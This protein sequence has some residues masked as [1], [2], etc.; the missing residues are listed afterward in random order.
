MKN[1][2]KQ[3]VNPL[4]GQGTSQSTK[5]DAT[6]LQR[7][8]QLDKWIDRIKTDGTPLGETPD[9]VEQIAM[10]LW[11]AVQSDSWALAADSENKPTIEFPHIDGYEIIEIIGQGGMGTVFRAR[12]LKLGRTV[13]LKVLLNDKLNSE[14]AKQRFQVEVQAAAQLNHPFIVTVY[15]FGEYENGLFYSMREIDGIDLGQFLTDANPD[16]DKPCD[17]EPKV[18][19]RVDFHSRE[20]Q[21]WGAEVGHTMADVLAHAHERLVIH[22]DVKP[23]NIIISRDG[24]AYLTDFGLARLN[25][26]SGLTEDQDVVGSLRYM[27]PEQIEDSQSVD[28]RTDIYSLGVTLYELLTGK[29]AVNQPSLT[30]TLRQIKEGRITR[31]RSIIPTIE[32]DLETIILKSISLEPELR[33]QTASEFRDDLNRYLNV[34]PIHAKPQVFTLHFNRWIKR[35]RQWV[36]ALGLIASSLVTV[37]LVF[38]IFSSIR[39]KRDEAIIRARSIELL[40]RAGV[41]KI[42]NGQALRAI[43][44]FQQAFELAPDD[45][46]LSLMTQRIDGI[47]RWSPSLEKVE[48]F[49]GKLLESYQDESKVT[50]EKQDEK[51]VC[52]LYSGDSVKELFSTLRIVRL[53][54]YS[55]DGNRCAI[56]TG[57][58]TNRNPE[59]QI[60]DRSRN[61]LYQLPIELKWRVTNLFF[62]EDSRQLFLTGWNGQGLIWDVVQRKIIRSVFYDG[63]SQKSWVFSAARNVNRKIMIAAAYPGKLVAYRLPALEP[64]WDPIELPQWKNETLALSR[65]GTWAAIDTPYGGIRVWHVE[66]GTEI[67]LHNKPDSRPTAIAFSNDESHLAVGDQFGNVVIWKLKNE[68]SPTASRHGMV[69]Q[70]DLAIQSLQFNDRM[71]LAVAT[72]SDVRVWRLEDNRNITSSIPVD[73]GVKEL[74]W[75]GQ[76]QLRIHTDG[77]LGDR[78]EIWNLPKHLTDEFV[79]DGNISNFLVDGS[80]VFV[81]SRLDQKLNYRHAVARD[82]NFNLAHKPTGIAGQ[83]CCSKN[84]IHFSLSQNRSRALTLQ[85]IDGKWQAVIYSF[86]DLQPICE[87]ISIGSGLQSVDISHDG[88]RWI[89]GDF[90]NRKITVRSVA[91]N[92]VLFQADLPNWVSDTCFLA[93]GSFAAISWDGKLRIWN[94]DGT[95]ANEFNHSEV[96][97]LL[98]S[99]GGQLIVAHGNQLSLYQNSRGSWQLAKCWEHQSGSIV[100]IQ[101]SNDESRFVTCGDNG[102][103]KL[104]SQD[105]RLISTLNSA[106]PV[107]HCQ[108]SANDRWLATLGR[109]GGINL[110][111]SETGKPMASTISGRQPIKLMTWYHDKIYFGGYSNGKYWVQ[112]IAIPDSWR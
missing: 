18:G 60:Y 87:P 92:K 85:I 77:K 102:Q 24:Q 50:V 53:A 89:W 3:E 82:K 19:P 108:F 107:S 76:N 101:F 110:W 25:E 55:P 1:K 30:S 37:I 32:S 93:D 11:R 99:Q 38:A 72:A 62:L 39:A 51:S 29:P 10:E 84:V 33:Y 88:K 68:K 80:E 81:V 8:E 41:Q 44:D 67:A 106:G 45:T 42:A 64:I 66:T 7:S 105:A 78:F 47:R 73:S 4:S 35:N 95:L 104:W 20:Y 111:E 31:P 70:H 27:S 109:A 57:D 15:A 52:L 21:R 94:V 97:D 69:M 16:S 83:Y 61:Q 48:R 5:M 49:R 46:E 96:P 36:A 79:S 98:R 2:N 12:D 17:Q 103:T 22:R 59:I 91:K 14:R 9:G 100:N 54:T 63:Q 58:R 112:N 74:R 40:D 56:L 75:L 13:A 26:G 43:N 34:L 90:Y 71:N 65:N 23:D 28:A 6:E 86:P